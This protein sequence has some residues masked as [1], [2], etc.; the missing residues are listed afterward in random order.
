MKYLCGASMERGRQGKAEVDVFKE[1][2][3]S[4]SYFEQFCSVQK[5][6]E[7][8]FQEGYNWK[9]MQNVWDKI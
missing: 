1:N 6:I 7:V 4:T 3:C 5:N 8:L 2:Y 9:R